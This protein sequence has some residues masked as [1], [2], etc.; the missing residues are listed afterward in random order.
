MAQQFTNPI[1]KIK[2]TDENREHINSMINDFD[3][4]SNNDQLDVMELQNIMLATVSKHNEKYG[5][6]NSDQ[7]VRK[8]PKEIIGNMTKQSLDYSQAC[9]N[10]Y[11]SQMQK[12]NKKR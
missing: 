2:V 6:P 4:L 3:R 10:Y 7:D 11:L 9:I 12:E 5:I 8:D 1:S